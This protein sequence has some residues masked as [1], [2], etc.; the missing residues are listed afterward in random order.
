MM[1]AHLRAENFWQSIESVYKRASQQT[2]R[3]FT[4]S[5]PPGEKKSKKSKN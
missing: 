4:N 2:S 1:A 3:L 5:E